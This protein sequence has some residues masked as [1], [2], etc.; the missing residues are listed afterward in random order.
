MLLTGASGFLAAHVGQQLLQR[1]YRVRGTVR[2]QEKGQY[3]VDLYKKDGLDKA[4][5]FVIV[6]DIEQVSC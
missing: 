4:F 2:S 1:G 6:E 5:E 3:L